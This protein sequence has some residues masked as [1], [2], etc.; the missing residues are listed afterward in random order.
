MDACIGGQLRMKGA[1]YNMTG[2]RQHRAVAHPGQDLHGRA[3]AFD[4]RRSYEYHLQRRIEKRAGCGVYEAVDLPA[5]GVAPD[6]DV[7]QIEAELVA[8]DDL[9]GQQD[10]AGAGAEDRTRL[11][12]RLK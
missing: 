1:D 6:A 10:G 2:A 4:D 8:T 3:D 9:T 11:G 5:V 12:K 7:N